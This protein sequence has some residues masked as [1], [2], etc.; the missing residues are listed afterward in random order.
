MS[1]AGARVLV[2]RA[3]EDAPGV[4]PLWLA[5]GILGLRAERPWAGRALEQAWALDPLAP[6]APYFLA[7]AAPGSPAAP[8]QAAHA[9]LAEPRLTAAMADD[10]VGDEDEPVAG[11]ESGLGDPRRRGRASAEAGG[12]AAIGP[13]DR[14]AS[15]LDRV[16]ERRSRKPARLGPGRAMPGGNAVVTYSLPEDRALPEVIRLDLF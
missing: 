5:A 12:G 13:L 8:V 11:P 16:C 1:L 9:L 10:A 7:V 6:F 15:A 4:A 3:A 14:A 2:T